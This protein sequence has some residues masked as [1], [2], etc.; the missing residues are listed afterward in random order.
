MNEDGKTALDLAKEENYLQIL[1]YLSQ[2]PVNM[3]DEPATL[4]KEEEDTDKVDLSST[5]NIIWFKEY[6][7]AVKRR[8]SVIVISSTVY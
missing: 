2:S 8:A 3:H 1:E 7:N 6:E 4:L 5:Q